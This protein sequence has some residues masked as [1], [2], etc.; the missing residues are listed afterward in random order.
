[1]KALRFFLAALA[2][3]CLLPVGQAQAGAQV[4]HV[5]GKIPIDEMLYNECN[6]EY[7]HLTGTMVW[8]GQL[9]ETR[10]GVYKWG[11][12]EIYQGVSGIGLTSG[13]TYR[14]ISGNHGYG[15]L[16]EG[17]KLPYHYAAGQTY[18]LRLVAQGKAPDLMEQNQVHV[19]VTP[20]FRYVVEIFDHTLVCK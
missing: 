18:K 16:I 8:N 15:S 3:L 5:G 9:V 20:D 7:V 14:G 19:T 6:D 17:D 12:Q 1:M 4:E 13:I 2:I 11:F 10:P